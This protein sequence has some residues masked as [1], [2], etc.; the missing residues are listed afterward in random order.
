MRSGRRAA[1]TGTGIATWLLS[2][3]A[4]LGVAGEA[5]AS[6]DRVSATTAAKV[7]SDPAQAQTARMNEAPGVNGV[8]GEGGPGIR[9]EEA[10]APTA[11]LVHL[12]CSAAGRA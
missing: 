12:A 3:V 9:G 11:L 4:G 1:T 2:G 6:I 10:G 7:R 8:S 5:G